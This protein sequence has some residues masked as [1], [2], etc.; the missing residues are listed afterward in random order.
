MTKKK[1][2]RVLKA[3]VVY[4]EKTKS[5]YVYMTERVT[6]GQVFKTLVLDVPINADY[7]KEGRLLGLEVLG[8]D[9]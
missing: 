6:K 5:M 1:G 9:L 7:T 3:R 2:L 4:D 8:V